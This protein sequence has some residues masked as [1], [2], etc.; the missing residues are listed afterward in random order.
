MKQIF[1]YVLALSVSGLF[2]SSCTIGSQGG[3]SDSLLIAKSAIDTQEKQRRER[4]SSDERNRGDCKDYR[5]CED[6][7]EEVYND[8][9]DRENEGKVE[10]CLDLPYQKAMSFEDLSDILEEPYYDDLTNIE[11]R[12]FEEFLEVSV[13]PW[14][15]KTKRLN[16]SESEALLRWIARDS[17]VAS[18]IVSA[19]ANLEDFDLYEGAQRLFEEI[20]PDLE[21]DYPGTL[22]VNRAERRCAEFCSAIANKSL[23]QSQSFWN[24][25]SSYSNVK[26]LEIACNIL[27]LNCKH[28]NTSVI[29]SIDI[30]HCPSD[31]RSPLN[32]GGCGL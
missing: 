31:I 16:N 17:K 5:E 26:G 7:C 13:A 15:E 12:D 11:A 20:A 18:A 21:S 2:L 22:A 9:D 29:G 30:L 32:A 10:K 25:I 27:L 4:N 28:E 24:I 1:F 6:V 14:V 23:A 8:E 3:G 19:Y